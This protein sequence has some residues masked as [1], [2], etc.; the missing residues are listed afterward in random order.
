MICRVYNGSLV[1]YLVALNRIKYHQYCIKT[2]HF[3]IKNKLKK[4]WG[5]G[6]RPR[7]AGETGLLSW[8][9][10]STGYKYLSEKVPGFAREVKEVMLQSQMNRMLIITT[11]GCMVHRM[12]V[13]CALY[14]VCSL[15]P[16]AAGWGYD[17]FLIYVPVTI[18]FSWTT[19]DPHSEYTYGSGDLI[20]FVWV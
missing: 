9:T 18:Q 11:F 15:C 7:V 2:R 12:R 8:T 3:Q 6:T 13:G 4:F 1:Y 14:R 17:F 20:P 16:S 19:D 5:G 10:L